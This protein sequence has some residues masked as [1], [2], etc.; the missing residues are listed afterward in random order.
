MSWPV[1]ATGCNKVLFVLVLISPRYSFF[2]SLPDPFSSER[3]VVVLV[4]MVRVQ[5]TL[6]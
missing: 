1:R 3:R 2:F 4:R 5:R 6:W